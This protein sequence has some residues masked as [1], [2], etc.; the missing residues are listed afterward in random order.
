MRTEQIYDDPFSS[1]RRGI[2]QWVEKRDGCRRISDDELEGFSQIDGCTKHIEIKEDT[3]GNC[4]SLCIRGVTKYGV[5]QSKIDNVPSSY[6]Y[7]Q[8]LE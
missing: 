8:G 7:Q 6:V 5:Q 1:K 4:S 3:L 2:Y